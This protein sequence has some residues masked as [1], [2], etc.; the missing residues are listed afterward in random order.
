[1]V[2]PLP[3]ASASDIILAKTKDEE[4][5]TLLTRQLDDILQETLPNTASSNARTK[6]VTQRLARVLYHLVASRNRLRISAGEEYASIVGVAK[7]A[8]G[9]RIIGAGAWVLRM[10]ARCLG[11]DDVVAIMGYLWRTFN[12]RSPFPRVGVEAVADYVTRVHLALFYL[13]A[14]FEDFGSRIANVR[15]LRTGREAFG[16]MR[17]SVLGWIMMI[18][19]GAD[20]VRAGM[21]CV[22]LARSEGG[23]GFKGVQKVCRELLWGSQA[24]GG[25][26]EEDDDEGRRCVLCMGG[27][28]HPTM[29]RCGHVFCWECICGWCSSHEF[30]PL[31]RQQNLTRQLVCLY[32]Y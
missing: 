14:R 16:A 23:Q 1:M 10:F 13:Y 24:G 12:V 3:A 26:E 15:Y 2:T 18:Q 31:C 9:T 6:K 30:C 32:N 28:K 11:R 21:R 20:A 8:R 17:L 19:I 4:Y 27:M 7:T 25:G 5:V 29:T 22:H